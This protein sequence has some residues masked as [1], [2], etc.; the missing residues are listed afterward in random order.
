MPGLLGMTEDE[1]RA[2]LEA[3]GLKIGSVD[4]V[5]SSAEAGSVVWQSQDAGAEVTKGSTVNIQISKGKNT[6][7]NNSP[8]NGGGNS[9]GQ[10][11]GDGDYDDTPS[12][13]SATIPVSVSYTHLTLPT[14][15]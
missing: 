13:G 9:G 14:K 4:S 15:A 10:D 5:D 3:K 12:L 2:A 8:D 11:N 7:N 1:A 6:S